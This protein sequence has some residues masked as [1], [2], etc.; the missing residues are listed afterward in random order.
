[1]LDYGVKADGVTDDTAAIQK[2][3][4]SGGRC[5][6]ASSLAIESIT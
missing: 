5:G 3:I 1:M 6:A 4:S 2:A